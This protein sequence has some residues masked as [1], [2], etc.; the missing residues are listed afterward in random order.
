MSIATMC[1]RGAS[2]LLTMTFLTL[3]HALS[4]TGA[5]LI[6]AGFC[7]V[8][9]L[10]RGGRM[11]YKLKQRAKPRPP[12]LQRKEETPQ[13]QLLKRLLGW[14]LSFATLIGI[15]AFALMVLP[16]VS[17]SVP[18]A[19]VDPNNVLSVS[20][21][22]SNTG[23]IPLNDI[24]LGVAPALI[25]SG[26]ASGGKIVGT[27]KPNGVPDFEHVINFQG[28][29]HHNLSLDERI[30]FDL[31]SVIKGTISKAD[32]AVVIS[33]TP[34]IVPLRREKRFRFVTMT[35][36]TGMTEWRSWPLDEIAPT[37]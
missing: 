6:Y 11:S 2:T 15:P 24:A 26:A 27:L 31:A 34:W 18:S 22:I 17:V 4:P 13:N 9:Y 36:E 30:T 33:Y 19:Q 10:F 8:N 7:I 3:T 20:F 32:I 29:Q 21:D 12:K 23:Y 37:H 28:W 5:F 35:S 16:R 14:L 1:L 25:D